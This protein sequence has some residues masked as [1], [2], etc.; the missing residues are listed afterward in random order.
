[1]RSS[2]AWIKVDGKDPDLEA[3]IR[4]EMKSKNGQTAANHET[5]ASALAAQIPHFID[6]GLF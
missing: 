6:G 1:M 2:E 5:R 3:P 4:A